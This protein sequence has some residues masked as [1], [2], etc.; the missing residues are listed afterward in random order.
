[1][2]FEE[3]YDLSSRDHDCVNQTS[4][5]EP[6]CKKVRTNNGTLYTDSEDSEEEIGVQGAKGCA[7]INVSA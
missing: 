4:G 3:F 1:M 6:S 2:K 5:I 7:V